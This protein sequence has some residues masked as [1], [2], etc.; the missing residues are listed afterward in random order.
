MI[1]FWLHYF[2]IALESQKDHLQRISS[3]MK[4]VEAKIK[5]I[6]ELDDISSKHN[7][8]LDTL[9]ELRYEIASKTEKTAV[10]ID[11]RLKELE[12]KLLQN[13]DNMIKSVTEIGEMSDGIQTNVAKSYEQLRL[14]VQALGKMEKVMI[15]TADNVMD[16]KRRIEYGVHQILLEVGDLVKIQSKDINTTLN[17]R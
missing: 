3:D 15:Q 9:Q 12:E 16:T 17:T 1:I 8:T 6:P 5:S 11:S 4:G 10:K 7:S 13:Q 2:L 14:E